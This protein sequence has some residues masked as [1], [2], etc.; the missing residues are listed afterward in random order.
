ME[1]SSMRAQIRN[2][3]AICSRDGENRQLSFSV[4]T[5]LNEK[6]PKRG[7]PLTHRCVVEM[8]HD[9]NKELAEL[10]DTVAKIRKSVKKGTVR[11]YHL[12]T[13][14]ALIELRSKTILSTYY[15]TFR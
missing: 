11:F 7:T 14:T 4:G 15:V 10:E 9:H 3:A 2:F 5:L 6:T 8:G 13:R 1:S 12:T